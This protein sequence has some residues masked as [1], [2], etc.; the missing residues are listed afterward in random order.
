MTV[1]FSAFFSLAN[2]AMAIANSSLARGSF[3]SE[4]SQAPFVDGMLKFCFAP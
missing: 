3:V 1:M 2:L 4:T